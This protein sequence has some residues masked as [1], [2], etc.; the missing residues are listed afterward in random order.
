M[1]K[2]A[3]LKR[4]FLPDLISWRIGS[5]TKDK[6]KGMALAY[7]DARTV[8]Q[9]LDEVCGPENWQCDYPHAGQKTVCRIGIK[10]GDEWIWK[11]NG[12]GDSDIEAEKGALSDAFKRAAVLWGIGQYLYDLDS[13]WVT[14]DTKTGSDGKVYVNGIAKHE[15]TRLYKLVGGKSANQLRQ[16]DD[17]FTGAWT[18]FL[19]DLW[20]CKSVSQ[21]EKLYLA[22]RKEGWAP[23]W[24]KQAADACAERKQQLIEA[25]SDEERA[26]MPP[27]DTLKASLNVLAGG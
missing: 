8:M 21:I 20:D 25:A 3:D 15:M 1:M 19:N 16:D 6:S 13:P 14:L 4:P 10:V 27:R 17:D 11:A 5:T 22:L 18:L 9:R 2:L 12:A 7:I 24:L 26:E 23:T